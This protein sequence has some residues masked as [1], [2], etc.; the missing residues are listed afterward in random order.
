[1]ARLLLRQLFPVPDEEMALLILTLAWLLAR[2]LWRSSRL[3]F[4]GLTLG[5]YGAL[6]MLG[7]QSKNA[8]SG[9]PN[10]EAAPNF[11]Q[12]PSSKTMFGILCST[13]ENVPHMPHTKLRQR[14]KPHYVIEVLNP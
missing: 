12:L 7:D 9:I 1:M 2:S 14:P 6:I 8:R 11:S 5:P 4:W 3:K 10:L 13:V